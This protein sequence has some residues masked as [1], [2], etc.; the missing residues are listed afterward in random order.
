MAIFSINVCLAH[1]SRV[2]DCRSRTN[3][4]DDKLANET[5]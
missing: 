2:H 5:M 4:R 1:L 3:N